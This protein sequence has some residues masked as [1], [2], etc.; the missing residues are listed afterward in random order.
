MVLK[1]S[2]GRDPKNPTTS[3]ND[4]N[5][6]LASI[7]Q[8]QLMSFQNPQILKTILFGHDVI[9][10]PA[11]FRVWGFIMTVVIVIS[12]AHEHKTVLYD[13]A[14]ELSNLNSS[15]PYQTEW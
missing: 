1:I 11:P 9:H 3:F 13:F 5:S 12:F 15:K 4:Q 6:A 14:F 7:V 8:S 10:T 2:V